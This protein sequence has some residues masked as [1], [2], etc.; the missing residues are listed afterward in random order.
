MM[1][2]VLNENAP[3]YL[4]EQFNK[5]K[6][7]VPYNLRNAD[8][9]LTFPKPNSE[10]LKKSFGYSGAIVWNSLPKNIRNSQTL[11]EF[12][13]KLKSYHLHHCSYQ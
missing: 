3:E 2:K 7:S 11:T 8:I 13:Q 10:C 4:Q 12:K 9:N 5:L 1:Y 6:T